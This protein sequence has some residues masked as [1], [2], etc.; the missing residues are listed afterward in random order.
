[1][2]VQKTREL[3]EMKL[4]AFDLPMPT[5]VSLSWQEPNGEYDVSLAL[6]L[7]GLYCVSRC[8]VGGFGGSVLCETKKEAVSYFW[9]YIE[10]RI[11]KTTRRSLRDKRLNEAPQPIEAATN[12]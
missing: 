10:E 11:E 9:A 5:G 8:M 1:M 6:R 3:R 12:A 4:D 7:D 2:P